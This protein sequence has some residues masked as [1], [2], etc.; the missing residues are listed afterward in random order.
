MEVVNG[1]SAP[2]KVGVGVASAETGQIV[3]Y[4]AY[5]KLEYFLI[6]PAERSLGRGEERERLRT[7][8]SVVIAPTGQLVTVAAHDKT[9]PVLVVYTV[10]VVKGT[11]PP[12]GVRVAIEEALV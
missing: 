2:V 7:I 6:K 5:N 4:K 3:V 9:V 1:I 8:V 12:V 10:D 11:S